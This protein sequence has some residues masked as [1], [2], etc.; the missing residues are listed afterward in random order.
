MSIR[1]RPIPAGQAPVR[2]LFFAATLA[3]A[4]AV[5]TP[6]IGHAAPAG[7]H[8][9]LN[10]SGNVAYIMCCDKNVGPQQKCSFYNPSGTR[11]PANE[12]PPSTG[13]PGPPPPASEQ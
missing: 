7:C 10:S 3:L 6:A 1:H 11:L 12:Q 9:V 13:E 8:K 5:A 2:R 4:A